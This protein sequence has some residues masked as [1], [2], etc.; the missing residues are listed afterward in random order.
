MNSS[1]LNYQRLVVGGALCLALTHGLRA[2]ENPEFP[3]DPAVHSV[4]VPFDASRPLQ[5]QK[6]ERYYL[7]YNAFQKL[8]D[9]AK[10]AR[11]PEKDKEGLQGEAAVVNLALHEVEVRE[12]EVVV[13][14][15]LQATTQGDWRTLPLEFALGDSAGSQWTLD[16]HAAPLK[17]GAVLIEKPGAHELAGKASRAL[18]QGWQETTLKLPVA[19]S[20]VLRVIVPLT[21][22]LPGLGA[23]VGAQMVSEEVR[24]GRR[25]FT[26]AL[27]GVRE[28]K[29]QREPARR[30]TGVA[31]PA[32]A[33]VESYVTARPLQEKVDVLARFRFPGT[34]RRQFSLEVDRDLQLLRWSATGVQSV[35]LRENEAR[36]FAEITTASPVRDEFTFTADFSRAAFGAAGERTAPYVG[37]LATRLERA[38]GLR[39]SPA[40][41]VTPVAGPE[42]ERRTDASV[43]GLGYWIAPGQATLKYKVEPAPNGVTGEVEA[44]YQ[45]SAEKVEILAAL[46]LHAGRLPLHEAYVPLVKGY[47][48]QSL[49]GPGIKS[50]QRDDAGV[51]IQFDASGLREVRI[52]LNL[53]QVRPPGTPSAAV[54]LPAVSVE[55]VLGLKAVAYLATH[56]ATETRIGLAP[57]TKWRE[58][59][60]TTSS[61]VFS[62][63]EPQTVKRALRWE[64]LDVKEAALSDL[65]PVSLLPQPAKYG[66]NAVLLAQ[67]TDAGLLYS[68]Q[69]GVQM[70]QGMLR[71]LKLSLPASLP[72]ARVR[73]ANIRDAQSKVVGDRREYTVGFQSDVLNTTAVTLD[74]ELPLEGTQALPLVKVDGATRARRFF[75][76][77]NASASEVKSSLQGVDETVAQ[78]VPY[79]PMALGQAQYFLGRND[80]ADVKLSFSRTEATAGNAAIVTLADITSALRPNGERWETVVYSLANRSLQFLPVRLPVGAELV[81]VTVGGERV[82]ADLGERDGKPLY[83]IPL[84]QMRPG[85]LSQQVQLVYRVDASNRKGLKGRTKL[86]DP[87]LVGLSAERTLWNVWVPE[88]YDLGSVDGN[89]E[90][91]VEEIYED[92][93]AQ[94]KLSDAMRLNRVA[95]SSNISQA[96]AQEA[97]G[98]AEKQLEELKQYQQSKKSSS[99]NRKPS[100]MKGKEFVADDDATLSKSNRQIEEQLQQQTL[101][102][103]ENR[104]KVPVFGNR[105]NGNGAMQGQFDPPQIPQGGV[106]SNSWAANGLVDGGQL[107]AGTGGFGGVPPL[108]NTVLN[109][110]VAVDNKFFAAGKPQSELKDQAAGAKSAEAKPAP[111]KGAN[112][113]RANVYNNSID[114]QQMATVVS[115]SIT[116]VPLPQGAQMNAQIIADVPVNAPSL[117]TGP[118]AALA[119]RDPFGNKVISTSSSGAISLMESE[120]EPADQ[121]APALTPAPSKPTPE[122]ERLLQSGYSAHNLGDYDGA[123]RSFQDAL[124]LDKDSSVARR[125]LQRAEQKRGEYFDTARDQQRAKMLNEVN[126]AWQGQT[127]A[128]LGGAAAAA[129]ADPFA[130]TANGVAPQDPFAPAQAQQLKPAGRLSLP[131]DVPLSGTVYHFRKLKDHATVEMKISR[132]WEP[133]RTASLWS[134]VAGLAVL[135]SVEAILRARRKR[136]R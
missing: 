49:T 23:G 60:V 128:I 16:G 68:Q 33:E 98:N 62:V 42:L 96:D 125:G 34:E 75:I 124:R 115:G 12:T 97:L 51:F 13:G 73:G 78:N 39:A 86:D 24:D 53:T 1:L 100:K 113:G 65:P 63:T 28:L 90:A 108:D 50:W 82:R 64:S 11:R 58:F 15:R 123:I 40:L 119:N 89:M 5:G 110:N 35:V 129:P 106:S 117:T 85:E 120:R 88:K 59:D 55:G 77:D 48:V 14:S 26:F 52:V 72:E 29:L 38:V 74:W 41:V 71:E 87:E 95:S 22:G 44:V 18:P 46:T 84:I 107:R 135:A 69:V 9:L 31:V 136:M 109:D 80:Q 126:Q 118:G 133:A 7:D 116:Q 83:L 43:A 61:S 104:L 127:P 36:K 47:E 6:P 92:E 132:P 70:D 130:S 105:T 2:Q 57:G 21:D 102:L 76:V 20:S 94:Q 54:M 121:F 111:S 93:K 66:V 10:E 27:A 91:V 79:L 30:A 19:V 103:G 17:D 122:V 101:V 112:L 131:V 99:Y 32:V 45:L 25:V 81:S 56:A 4:I 114:S 3:A 8:W 37:A 134:L 67:A